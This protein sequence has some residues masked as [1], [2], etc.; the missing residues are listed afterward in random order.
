MKS[1]ISVSTYA[2]IMEQAAKNNGKATLEAR[3]GPPFEIL[4]DADFAKKEWAEFEKILD[5]FNEIPN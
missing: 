5:R 3:G 2:S 1:W 4:I